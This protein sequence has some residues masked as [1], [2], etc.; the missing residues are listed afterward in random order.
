MRLALQAAVAANTVLREP[1][2]AEL[3]RDFYQSRLFESVV[4]HSVWTRAHYRKA[5]PGTNYKFWHERSRGL[6]RYCSG[7]PEFVTLLREACA[8]REKLL[9][10]GGQLT[11]PRSTSSQTLTEAASSLLEARITLSPD[12]QFVDMP[13]VIG[14][15]VQLR[16]AITHPRLWEPL[17]FLAGYELV[18]LLKVTSTIK[19]LRQLITNW[20]SHMPSPIA[21]QIA[22]WLRLRGV[23][24][25]DSCK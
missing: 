15:Y 16:P 24:D 22:G 2:K 3:A 20:S 17:V 21:A 12:I 14:D 6:P 19:T 23:F 11:D 18:P 10:G 5:W 25:V 7:E 13:C 1:Q 4:S 9:A 8:K